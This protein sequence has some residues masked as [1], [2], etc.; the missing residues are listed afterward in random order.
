MKN[1]KNIWID[2]DPGLDDTLAIIWAVRQETKINWKILGISTVKGNISFQQT[3]INALAILEHLNRADIPVYA[4]ASKALIQQSH[5]AEFVHGNKLGPFDP[6][7]TTSLQTLKAPE[8]LAQTLQNLDGKMTIVTLGPLTNIALFL[9]LYPELT[10]KIENIVIMGGGSY[11]NVTHYAEFNIY[12]DPEAAWIVFNSGVSITMSGL[13]ISDEYAFATQKELNFYSDLIQDSWTK[14]VFE[15][16]V[17]RGFEKTNLYDPT[18][19]V[20]AA[21]PELFETYDSP[22]TV[23]LTGDARGM[24]LLPTKGTFDQALPK[25]ITTKVL[26]SCQRDLF[27]QRLFEG[28]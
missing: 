14:P 20:A 21:Y 18:A 1:L 17:S 8:A 22:V 2:T 24:T 9:T 28:L 3:N 4:G 27:H 19:M 6:K 15:F 13:D 11:G 25:N 7:P 23:Q 5:D 16:L 26:K 12:I 10:H